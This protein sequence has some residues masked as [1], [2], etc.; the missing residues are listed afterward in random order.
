L[1]AQ[2]GGELRIGHRIGFAELELQGARFDSRFLESEFQIV[3]KGRVRELLRGNIN[4]HGETRLAS[5]PGSQLLAGLLQNPF[6]NR[7][8]E[9]CTLSN[10]KETRRRNYPLLGVIPPNEGFHT[11]ELSSRQV[12][13]GLVTEL[14]LAP[15]DG[16]AQFRLK[17]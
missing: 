8:H 6:T 7:H 17:L 13:N 5:L 3:H 4:G 12:K 14:K 2:F 10:L 15:V 11:G 9:A 16:R 1:C